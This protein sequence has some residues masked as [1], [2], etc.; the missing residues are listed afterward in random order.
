MGENG[1]PG[2]RGDIKVG[3][4][5]VS[6]DRRDNGRTV[7]VESVGSVI[8]GHGYVGVRNVRRSTINVRTLL[9]RYNLLR[10]AL[11]ATE[12]QPWCAR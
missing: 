3:S 9:E 10:E 8:N 7:T 4:V 6:R 1:Q 2:C 11:D 5:W 12:G